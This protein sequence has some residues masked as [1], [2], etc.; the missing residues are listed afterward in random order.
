[1]DRLTRLTSILIQLQSKKIIVAKE[2]ADRFE[3]SLRTVYRDIKTLQDAGVPIGSENGKGY[4]LVSGY[5]LPP[6]MLNEKEVNTL[7]TAEKLIQNQED[8]SLQSDFS[9]LLFKIKSVLREFQKENY[10]KLE[11]RIAPSYL[12]IPFQS[13]SLSDFKNAIIKNEI[14]EIIYHSIHKKEISKRTINPLGVYFSN[15]A[16]ILVSFCNNKKEYREFRLDRIT[17]Y[18]FTNSKF[19]NLTDFDLT[20]YFIEKYKPK[21]T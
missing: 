17:D 5:H 1:M 4:F 3:I 11:N 2:I 7:V 8:N 21:L 20:K 14:V 19:E 18:K 16:W 6:I 10:E 13:N 12:K 9:S 15:K